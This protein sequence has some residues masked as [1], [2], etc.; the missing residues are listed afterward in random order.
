MKKDK[1]PLQKAFSRLNNLMTPE[2]RKAWNHWR[3]ELWHLA[4]ETRD[5]CHL[6]ILK[7]HKE[8]YLGDEFMKRVCDIPLML[9]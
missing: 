7:D 5:L 4:D 8:N 2:E 9:E 1:P 3:H 6:S